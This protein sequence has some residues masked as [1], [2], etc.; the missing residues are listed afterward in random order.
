[1]SQGLLGIGWWDPL[2]DLDLFLA[3]KSDQ[4]SVKSVPQEL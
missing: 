3:A 4:M 2:T 1:L